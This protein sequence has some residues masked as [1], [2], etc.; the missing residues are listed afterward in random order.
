MRASFVILGYTSLA[1]GR[2][3]GVS[4]YSAVSAAMVVRLSTADVAMIA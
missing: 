3:T 1:G 2:P 4:W